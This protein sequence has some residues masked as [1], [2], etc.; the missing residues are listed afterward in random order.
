MGIKREVVGAAKDVAKDAGHEGVGAIE[1]E[2]QRRRTDAC[3]EVERLTH[4]LDRLPKW[5]WL[6]RAVTQG[7]L[8]RAQDQCK[9][10]R[11]R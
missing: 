5:R 10:E 11:S 4:K 8:N 9:A 3:A 7:Q 1:R 2:V 6:A